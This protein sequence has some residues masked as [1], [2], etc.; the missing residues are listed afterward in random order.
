MIAGGEVSLERPKDPAHGDY[1]TNVALQAARN[2]GRSPREIAAELAAKV[3]ELPGI[4]SAEVAGPGFLNL[5]V[6]DEFL[7]E[8]LAEIDP[9]YGGGF[10]EPR[11]TIQVEMVSANPTGPLTV[12]S[13]RN[14]ALGD[15]VARLL[16]FAGHSVEREYYWNDAGSADG[17]VPR[18]RSRPLR[19]RRSSPEDGY[20]GDYMA[21]LAQTAGDPVPAMLEQIKGTLERFRIRF[22]SFA[23][24]SRARVPEIAAAI[25]ALDTY[26]AGRDAVWREPRTSATTR[27]ARSSAPRKGG[28]HL[29]FAADVAYLRHKLDR[30]STVAIYVLGADH[31]ATSAGSA[32]PPRCSATTRSASRCSSTSSSI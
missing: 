3:V 17:S 25:A 5:R 27:I 4:E 14:G 28:C 26:E 22:D 9:G 21:D 8:A 30:G 6:N 12:A 11:E 18:I 23:R 16:Q 20:H 19:R 2:L 31:T 32:P 7:A 1:A 24:E 13:A 15:S 10:A 29:Y